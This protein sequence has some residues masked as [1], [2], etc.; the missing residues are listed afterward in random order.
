MYYFIFYSDDETSGFT[1]KIWIT[2]FNFFIWEYENELSKISKK[3]GINVNEGINKN[4][5]LDICN[6]LYI[7]YKKIDLKKIILN[8]IEDI[9]LPKKLYNQIKNNPEKFINQKFE[10][11]N[12]EF[13][14]L[15]T[16][17]QIETLKQIL[18]LDIA[19]MKS[20]YEIELEKN[21]NR[22][23]PEPDIYGIKILKNR[24]KK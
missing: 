8:C 14:M 1:N 17:P 5:F 19:V 23:N 3:H 4:D 9:V 2:L 7:E 18:N 11:R 10:R 15:R 6:I 24:G 13:P 21:K 16:P 12:L 20:Q 22:I